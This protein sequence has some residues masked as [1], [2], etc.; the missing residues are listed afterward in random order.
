MGMKKVLLAGFVLFSL[1]LI[2][3]CSVPNLESEPCRA[4]RDTVK[5]FY[6]VHFANKISPMGEIEQGEISHLTERLATDLAA[7]PAEGKDYFT[8]TEDFPM[9]FRVG[10]CSSETDDM[11]IFQ[12]VLLW[13]D[14]DRDDQSEVKVTA[15][16]SGNK[17]LID[18][19]AH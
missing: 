14:D 18:R 11:T 13:R 17:W 5:R 6:S 2:N 8:Q 1:T 10:S 19:V 3:A 12:V 7:S 4:A 16:R 9:A 15:L